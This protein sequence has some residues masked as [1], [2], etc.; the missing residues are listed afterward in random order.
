MIRPK[1]GDRATTKTASLMLLQA[2]RRCRKPQAL[3]PNRGP[4]WNPTLMN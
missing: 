1:H 2:A 3:G 4:I